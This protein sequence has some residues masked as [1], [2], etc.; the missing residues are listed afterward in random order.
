MLEKLIEN[1]LNSAGE[2]T[3]QPVFCQMLARQGYTVIHSTRH[4]PI[5]YGK[6][7]IAI[8][9]D[10]T[11]CAFQLKGN[12]GSRLTLAQYREIA[13]QLAELVNQQIE[14]PAISK[15]IQHRTFLVTNGEIDEEVQQA[16]EQTNAS[17]VR[18]G[19]P[20]RILQTMAKGQLL[21]W[22]KELDVSLWPSELD[23]TKALLEILTNSGNELFPAGKFHELLSR[24][25][26]L[27]FGQSELTAAEFNRRI[28]SSALFT[29]IC[30]TP[31]SKRDNHWAIISAWALFSV[32]LIASA[33][34]SGRPEK[35][36][37]DILAITEEAIFNEL[38]SLMNE[39]LYRETPLVEGD[40][41][42]DFVVYQWRYTL[43]VGIG[44][45]T[46]MWMN[47]ADA[48]PNLDFKAKLEKFLPEDQSTLQ[49][50][51]DAAVPQ[52]LLHIWQIEAKG[53]AKKSRELLESLCNRCVHIHLPAVYRD[54]EAVIEL[55]L[56]ETLDDF[57]PPFSLD[58][59]GPINSWMTKQLVLHMA[60]HGMKTECQSI[61]AD[62]SKTTSFVFLPSEPWMYGL[63]KCSHGNNMQYVP[64]T[65]EKWENVL[66][67]ANA[68]P[69][70]N[71]PLELLSRPW[72]LALWIL[73]CPQRAI[74]AAINNIVF[75]AAK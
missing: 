32:Y 64:K 21:A 7:I 6:D 35:E 55:V 17:N 71:I 49:L 56:S 1:W 60:R 37:A 43:L 13:P 22:A 15:T 66:Q 18:S 62:Y 50:W 54:V 39:T 41:L 46:W 75:R 27:E 30:L 40:S 4:S 42:S 36:V 38:T 61:W 24:L 10:G 14:H 33:A 51:G 44:S 57:D 28:S 59:N 45:L 52:F 67:E 47:H 34:K 2:R 65:P 53:N 25:L 73:I 8:H 31:F 29:A 19:Y 48:W 58:Q 72:L 5:E 26:K 69:A 12:P 70:E 3:Y 16:I 63:F 11:P 20:D 68:N 74:P 23:D 9:L